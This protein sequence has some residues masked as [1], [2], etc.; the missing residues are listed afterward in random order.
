[1][2]LQNNLRNGGVDV[3]HAAERRQ[4]GGSRRRRVAVTGV[5]TRP[6]WC[7]KGSGRLGVRDTVVIHGDGGMV[8]RMGQQISVAVYAAMLDNGAPR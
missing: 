5:G 6:R 1:V 3:G 2:R 4:M 8:R 7:M